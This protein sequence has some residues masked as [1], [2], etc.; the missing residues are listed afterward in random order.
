M[1]SFSY[2]PSLPL[3]IVLI[4]YLISSQSFV[5]FSNTSLFLSVETK[6]KYLSPFFSSMYPSALLI[7]RYKGFQR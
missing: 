3:F 4:R 7:I 6:V 1:K 2:S 5:Y